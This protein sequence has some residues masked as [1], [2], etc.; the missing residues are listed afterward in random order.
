[1]CETQIEPYF[2]LYATNACFLDGGRK[3]L[4]NCADLK[5]THNRAINIIVSMQ[6]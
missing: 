2:M 3:L 6:F 4:Q 1:M 5:K